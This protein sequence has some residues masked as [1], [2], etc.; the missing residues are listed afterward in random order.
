LNGFDL[1]IGEQKK[2]EEQLQLHGIRAG[3]KHTSG[4]G[5]CFFGLGVACETI[6]GQGAI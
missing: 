1:L 5:G 6:L 2:V 3:G 4:G